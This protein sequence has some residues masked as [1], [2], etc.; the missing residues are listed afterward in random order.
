MR[1]KNFAAEVAAVLPKTA[2]GK[3]LEIWFQDEARVGQQGTLT[4]IWAER[5]TRPRAP[6]DTRYT[7]G[8]IFGA[9]CPERAEAAAL[10]MPHADTS[11][12]NAHLCEIARTVAAG[13]HALLILDGAGWHGS[14]KLE[15]PDNITL[16]K[17]PPYAPELNPME[18]VWATC[19]PTSWQSLCLNP[20]MRSSTN[21]A[22]PGI[23]SQR[24]NRQSHQLHHVIGPKQS[25]N[26]A[27]GIIWQRGE[28][29]ENRIK[30][31]KLDF[32]G[33]TLPCSDFVANALY[34]LISALSYN[35]F[36]LMRHL[37][38]GELSQH[39]DNAALGGWSPS[40]Q[41]WLERDVNS[42][43][44]CG[45]TTEYSPNI[46]GTSATRTEEV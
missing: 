6:R 21:A 39:C 35:L 5:G 1:L 4:R 9:V 29:S 42:W 25:I 3:P 16:L 15:V 24:T 26:R 20:T 30:E 43:S 10:I 45:K 40:R 36:A 37:L 18:N 28:D 22:M 2:C 44:K 19:A 46:H 17:L 8:Y 23:S 33:D 38:P 31:L 13:A 34:F 12:M 11:A 32:G 7:S 41:K 14:A 27:V